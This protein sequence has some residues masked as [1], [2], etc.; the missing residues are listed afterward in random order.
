MACFV[1]PMVEAVITTIA[2]KVVRS[3]EGEP[4][5]VQI[6]VDGAGYETAEKI[7]FSR[8]LGWLSKLLWGGSALLMFEHVW[9]G[10]IIPAFPFLSAANNPA[11]LANMLGEMSTVGVG[12]AALITAV[13]LGMATIT[14]SMEKKAVE[15]R[16]SES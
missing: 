15:T 10:E 1:V 7:T 4:E 5:T 9:T 13:W 2:A 11:D 12:M 3:H 16:S 8:K 14:S 6:H